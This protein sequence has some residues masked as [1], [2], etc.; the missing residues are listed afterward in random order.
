MSDFSEPAFGRASRG[1]FVPLVTL[2]LLT[3]GIVAARHP[4]AARPAD[5]QSSLVLGDGLN[6]P[7]GFE[8]APE[9]TA[10]P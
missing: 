4:V 8:I 10:C 9:S 1:W 2:T 3:L 6:G 7:A 5:F